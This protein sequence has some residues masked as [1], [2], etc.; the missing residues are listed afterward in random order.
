MKLKI[1]LI[2]KTA[3]G[4]NLRSIMPAIK[5]QQLSRVIR[6]NANLKC[7]ICGEQVNSIAN[8]DAHE[9]WRFIKIRKK[10]GKII[11]KQQLKCIVAVCKKCHRVIHIGRTSYGKH[12]D[13]AVEHFLNVNHC[14]YSK[15]KK[16]EQKAYR[17]WSRRSQHKWKLDVDLDEIWEKYVNNKE[18]Q[19]F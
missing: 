14:R 11:R 17:K 15:F 18:T 8:L 4:Q 2:P 10:S 12:Y 13:E 1:E 3:Y 7:E 6:N 5:W 19:I 9:V 16:A